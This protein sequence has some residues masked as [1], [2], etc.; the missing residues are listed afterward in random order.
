MVYLIERAMQLGLF[1][2]YLKQAAGP[3]D[4]SLRYKG[5]EN[6]AVHQQQWLIP[7]DESHFQPGLKINEVSKYARRYLNLA[8]ASAVIEQFRTYQDQTLSRWTTV[9]M[10][11][12]ELQTRG[13]PITPQRI[14]GYIEDVPEWQHKLQ[15]EEF[16][17]DLIASTL[18]GLQKL[19]F[20]S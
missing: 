12:R 17:P 8:Q 15:R 4:P 20:L 3:Y 5:P 19:R 13:E 2:N 18:A 16:S 11:A 14:W 1:Q 9:E 6:I 7:V 10:A